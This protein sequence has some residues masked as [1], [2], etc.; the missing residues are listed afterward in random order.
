MVK[1]WVIVITIL[2][3]F[4]VDKNGAGSYTDHM[5]TGSVFNTEEQCLKV[6]AEENT[7]QPDAIAF[8]SPTMVRFSN[9]HLPWKTPYPGELK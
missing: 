2:T 6:V 8:C 7:N 5:A 9:E 3:P 1:A 4:Y